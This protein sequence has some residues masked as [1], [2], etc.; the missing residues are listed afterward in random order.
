[1]FRHFYFVTRLLQIGTKNSWPNFNILLDMTTKFH[2]S[3]RPRVIALQTDKPS[4]KSSS[5]QTSLRF[6]RWINRSSMKHWKTQFGKNNRRGR[7]SMINNKP[8]RERQGNDVINGKLAN[9]RGQTLSTSLYSWP[10]H[11]LT[12]I[13]FSIKFSTIILAKCL[14]LWV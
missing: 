7:V 3:Y 6:I 9:Y 5:F 12:V 8:E 4:A 2:R 1:M 11:S 14:V 10:W 13:C